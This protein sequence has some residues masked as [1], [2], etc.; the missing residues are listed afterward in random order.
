MIDY[1][2]E[3]EN[4][5][6]KR[7]KEAIGLTIEEML[8]ETNNNIKENFKNKGGVGNIIESAWFGI[9]PN[10]LAEP[11]FTASGIE[12]K[13]IPLVETKNKQYR[14]KERTKICSINYNT[15]INENW[16]TSHVKNKINKILFMYYVY[17]K[18]NRMKSIIKK[19][20]LFKLELN[21]ESMIRKDWL[22]VYDYVIEGKA[23]LLSESINNILTASRYGSGGKLPNGEL[24]DLVDQPIKTYQKKA[25]KRAFSFKPSFT[26]QLWQELNDE[27]FESIIETLKIDSFN[28]ENRIIEKLNSLENKSIKQISKMFDINIPKGKNSVATVIKKALGFKNVN[29][30]IKEFEQLG[31]NVKTISTKRNFEKKEKDLFP[32][33]AVSFPSFKLQEFLKESFNEYINEN[34]EIIEE[35]NLLTNIRRILFITIIDDNVTKK[36]GKAF[37]WSPSKEELKTIEKEWEMYRNEVAH[38]KAQ[39]TK[40]YNSNGTFK[41]INGFT[42]S[43]ETQ[44]LHLRPH[45]RDRLDRDEDHLGNSIVKQSFWLNKNFLQKLLKKEYGIN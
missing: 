3:N 1:T 7:A 28:F 37:F 2:K 41:E 23:H 34:G 45:A 42:N 26:N 15:L 12:L 33:E 32:N 14:V 16:K 24:K 6:I 10:N 36:L 4:V 5:I 31:I 44:I 25:L 38:G 11:D 8:Y 18:N 27:K 13:I 17:N 21:N 40:K 22:K 20:D 9:K 30:K 19:I 35:C 29:S 39:I 43:S